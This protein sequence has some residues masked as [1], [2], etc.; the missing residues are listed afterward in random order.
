MNN[1][2][3]REKEIMYIPADVPQACHQKYIQAMN[4]ITK[5]TD[6]VL[7]FAGDQ[8]LEHLHADFYGKNICEQD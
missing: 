8:K 7:M 4:T 1:L 6:H 5:N 2:S 3:H